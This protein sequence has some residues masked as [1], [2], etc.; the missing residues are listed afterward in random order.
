MA[1]SYPIR[2]YP[3]IR[4][5]NIIPLESGNK[6]LIKWDNS[7]PDEMAISH[8]V[9]F[10]KYGWEQKLRYVLS[11]TE[12]FAIVSPSLGADPLESYNKFFTVGYISTVSLNN[13]IKN[14]TFTDYEIDENT[15]QISSLKHF[16][17]MLNNAL[18]YKT[19]SGIS[20]RSIDQN[21]PVFFKIKPEP[22]ITKKVQTST[23]YVFI[24]VANTYDNLCG[25]E[26]KL[27][28]QTGNVVSQ[29]TYSVKSTE[30]APLI[31][32]LQGEP[33]KEYT[34]EFAISLQKE[35]PL[36]A[37]LL[38]INLISF[39]PVGG[40][41]SLLPISSLRSEDGFGGALKLALEQEKKKLREFVFR[42]IGEKFYL[43]SRKYSGQRC[44]R[45]WDEDMYHPQSTTCEI[46]YGTGY[47][48][49][50]NTYMLYG[51][52]SHPRERYVFEPTQYGDWWTNRVIELET[53]VDLPIKARDIIVR[54]DGTR[55]IVGAIEY[56]KFSGYALRQKATL[57]LLDSSHHYYKVPVGDVR[58][59]ILEESEQV[60]YSLT[61]T[62]GI[63]ESEI[64]PMDYLG[65][66]IFW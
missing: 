16:E 17:L 54:Q 8:F 52:F 20:V 32:F 3:A 27:T 18:L 55:Y 6:Y 28:D 12:P 50:Y 64:L 9:L 23:L 10:E 24:I 2:K 41:S 38:D 57:Y 53:I 66:V 62:E 65:K 63:F 15:W 29:A 61:P 33:E 56:E 5:L 51:I 48:G 40:F 11:T 7:V 1:L 14:G 4:E 22:F 43:L 46:C 13:L 37:T 58:E 45:C 39:Y 42:N 21:S 35:P 31:G 36:D 49:G 26:L 19:K 30:M 47:V 34:W 25:I 59:V 60:F 44:P